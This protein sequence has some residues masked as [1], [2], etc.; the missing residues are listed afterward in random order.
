[1]RY[2]VYAVAALIGLVVLLVVGTG[3]A[4]RAWGPEL[5]RERIE[6]ALT[7]SLG[8]ETHVAQ[9]DVEFWR[10]RVVVSG[11]TVA[12]RRDE[13]GPHFVTLGRVEAQVGVSSLWRRRLVLRWI[14]LDDVDLALAGGGDGDVTLREI[15]MLPEVVHAGLFDVEL[16]TIEVR[17]GRVVYADLPRGVRAG[18]LG[19]SATAWRERD[20]T[21]LTIAADGI[22]VETPELEERVARLAMEVRARPTSI[23]LRRLVT[24]WE[25]RPV[26]V[27][28]RV[29][30]P[31]DDPTLDLTA[32]ADVDLEQARRRFRVAWPLQGIVQTTV[33]I[34]GRTQGLRVAADVAS[35][36][37]RA[38]SVTTYALAAR[39]AF[40]DRVVTVASLKARAFDGSVIGD[41][42]IDLAHPERSHVRVTLRDAASGLL[43]P[44]AG[45]QTGGSARLDADVQVRGDLRDLVRARTQVRVAA[46][47]I[48]LPAVAPLGTGTLDAEAT[49]DQGT[50]DLSN[51]VASWPGLRLEASGRATLEGPVPLRVKA[52]G[53]LSRLAPLL[54]QTQVTGDAVLDAEV[55]GR[56]RD[57]VLA[58]R[59]DVRSPG[60]AQLRA[61]V[62]GATFALTPRSLRLTDAS[63]GL[64]RSRIVA[65]GTLAWPASNAL[66]VPAPGV[67]ALDLIARTE[68]V[69]VEDAAPWL[70]A[71]LL[72]SS[73]PVG[74][75][76]R[77]DGTLAAWH[78]TGRAE[79]SGLSVPSAPPIGDVS[80][81]F[82]ATAEHLA[83]LALRAR[84]L[85][86]PVSAKGLWRWAGSGEVE[87]EAGPVDLGRLP[88]LPEGIGVEGRGRVTVSATV[89]D[90]VVAG[91]AR[92]FGERVA[93]AGFQLGRGAARLS[94]DGAVVR[95]EAEFPEAR[96]AATGQG[97]LEEGAVIAARVTATTLEIEPLLRTYRPDLVGM[98]AGRFSATVAL[99]VP[100][101][102]PRA[103]RGV[104]RLE[105]VELDAGGEHWEVRG[106]VVIRREPGRLT[107][108]QLELTGRLG[109]ATASGRLDDGGAL[110]GAVHGQAPLALLSAF[111]PEI[112][113][114]SGRL[115][116]DVRIGGS[117]AKPTL[118]GRGTITD[119]VVVPRDTPLV[120]R[121]IEARVSMVPTRLRIEEL[122][123]R[124][125][126]GTVSATGE[127]ALDGSTIG[128]YQLAL[129]GRG[130][131]VTPLEGLETVWNADATLVGRGVRG[132][133]RGDVHLV[134]GSYTRDLSIAPM[135]LK[136][137]APLEPMAWGRELGLQVDLHLDDNLVVRSPQARVRAGGMLRLRGTVAQPAI[138][139]TIA[140]QDG[141]VTFRR[142]VFTL[143]NAVVRFD[144]PRSVNP[145]LEV[146][147]TTRIRT[148]DVTMRLSGRAD[149]LTIRL[150]SEPPLPQEDL[151]ALVTLGATRAE[152]GSSGALT[153]AGEA[154]Q[155]VSR[156]LLGLD[157]TTS[158][159]DILEF[160][161]SDTGQN[162][163]RV[164]K[165]LTDRTTVIYSGSSS[166]GGQQK[167]RIEYQVLGPL[168]LAGEQVFTGGFGGDVILRLRFR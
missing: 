115:D 66:A 41:G 147:A 100:A 70:P 22:S 54:G 80:V 51:A 96:I 162:E 144:D 72:G 68:E 73:G 131:T 84:V 74:V 67:V 81:S 46:R 97:R 163:F 23:E 101:R 91:T 145:Y 24:T 17:R 34:Q 164:G 108:E 168:L 37:V 90:G 103:A 39:L 30:G 61:D 53:D 159:V 55:T 151:L 35:K 18:V 156:E 85:D 149:D 132:L 133:V 60:L 140:T 31:F 152:L 12:A 130:L 14:R 166:E 104:I 95:G 116:V 158:Y 165:R 65:T 109:T 98:V 78:A 19:V 139:G 150:N 136:E 112:R 42:A 52:T 94:S 58:G 143:E 86:G 1:M 50:F 33:R 128:A 127:I 43:E 40:A 9:V 89:R 63:V 111:R 59:L 64:G 155:M 114:A 7:S 11:V 87:A 69:R 2:V 77:I 134:R 113:E 117:T 153:F 118:V 6:A 135:L 123:A 8:R 126:G 45:L 62:V 141:R 36:E 93:V 71:T 13:P 99:D 56:W 122:H 75:T 106:P 157:S 102:D 20:A 124:V 82:D 120:V 142:N 29:D 119:G 5:A 154:A 137:R 110:E 107:L 125:S 26:A 160:R 4:V 32:R 25:Q 57:P 27:T 161:R 79:S 138:L 16:G 21:R 83:V 49:G 47:E 129:T 76:A 121:D 146:R 167:L 88:G 10:G 48:R 15:P 28:G 105:P 92:A 148:Y 38:A 3:F 44:L